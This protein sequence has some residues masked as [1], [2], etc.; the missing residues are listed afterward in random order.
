MGKSKRKSLIEADEFIPGPGRY[1]IAS[2]L[3][4]NSPYYT[5]GMKEKKKVTNIHFSWPWE[6]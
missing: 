2:K 3:G 4:Q 6:I 1:N 5:M